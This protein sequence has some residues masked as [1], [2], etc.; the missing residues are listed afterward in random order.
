MGAP[1]HDM[2]FAT[3]NPL[4]YEPGTCGMTGDDWLCDTRYQGGAGF[5]EPSIP[6]TNFWDFEADLAAMGFPP[7]GSA[8]AY[9]TGVLWSHS[10]TAPDATLCVPTFPP[11][12]GGL[13]GTTTIP[14]SSVEDDV[15]SHFWSGVMERRTDNPFPEFPIEDPFVPVLVPPRDCP[16]CRSA[17]GI[18]WLVAAPCFRA[19]NCGLDHVQ[20]R[21]PDVGVPAPFASTAS[22][23]PSER[24][25]AAAD[26]L[27]VRGLV[28]AGAR[29]FAV[30]LVNDGVNVTARAGL[31]YDPDYDGNLHMIE[32][33]VEF[34]PGMSAVPSTS[35]WTTSSPP[36][37]GQDL[38]AM[39]IAA[40]GQ[41]YAAGRADDEPSELWSFDLFSKSWTQLPLEV[42]CMESG[43]ACAFDRTRV[44]RVLAIAAVPRTSEFLL[45]VVSAEGYTMLVRQESWGALPTVLWSEPLYP[46]ADHHAL[47]VDVKDQLWWVAWSDA[48]GLVVRV[49]SLADPIG[50]LKEFDASSAVLDVA[51]DGEMLS[52]IVE[53]HQPVAQVRTL[54]LEDLDPDSSNTSIEDAL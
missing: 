39:Y 53:D 6:Y 25:F 32:G 38:V 41:I 48:E 49:C 34:W 18:G 30:S 24:W 46:Q 13:C 11:G 28:E 10:T 19:G 35:P 9:A 5:T 36:R 23:D 33:S 54:R 21:Y 12:P 16:A 40:T 27:R 15:A 47:F 26:L 43:V 14:Y 1:W 50:V 7:A 37:I 22:L 4:S 51:F 52:F 29:P 31:G 45:T 20:L 2:T 42:P 8:L 3:A 17:F 44:D